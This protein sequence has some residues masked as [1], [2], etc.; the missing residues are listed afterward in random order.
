MAEC[1]FVDAMRMTNAAVQ[2]LMR[3]EVVQLD[4]RVVTCDSHN[5]TVMG[6]SKRVCFGFEVDV[7][8]GPR[9]TQI[10]VRDAAL[11]SDPAQQTFG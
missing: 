4:K 9:L 11:L 7:R 6:H 5:A 8:S 2:K 10:P 1:E 3:A